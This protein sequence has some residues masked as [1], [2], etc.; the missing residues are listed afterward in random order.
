MVHEFSDINEI[1]KKIE[2]TLAYSRHRERVRRLYWW[3][4]MAMIVM[5]VAFVSYVVYVS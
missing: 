1:L 5:L 3:T 4:A 2:R